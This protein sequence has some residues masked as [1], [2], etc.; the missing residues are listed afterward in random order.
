MFTMYLFDK[1]IALRHVLSDQCSLTVTNSC[2]PLGSLGAKSRSVPRFLFVCTDYIKRLALS[3]ALL[4]IRHSS[5][6]KWPEHGFN[7]AEAT[8]ASCRHHCLNHSPYS[9]PSAAVPNQTLPLTLQNHRPQKGPQNLY[10]SVSV[11]KKGLAPHINQSTQSL[12]SGWMVLVSE[13][14][15]K[16]GFLQSITNTGIFWVQSSYKIQEK[17]HSWLFCHF[18]LLLLNKMFQSSF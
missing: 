17:T 4:V 16:L 15:M 18:G 13:T 3:P 2:F 11:L 10:R 6:H 1:R 12:R 14:F 5:V 7:T 9:V 8:N